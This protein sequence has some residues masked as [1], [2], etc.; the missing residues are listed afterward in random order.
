MVICCA[1]AQ[2]T[3]PAALASVAWADE[4][5]VVDS[6]STD[7][8]AEIARAAADRYV[9]E[10]WRGYTEQKKYGASLARHD[11]V[12][13]LDGDEEVS[14]ALAAELR[15]LD[16]AAVDHLDVLTMPRRNHVL[17]RPVR[18]WWPDTQSRLIHRGR[19]RWSDDVL[20]D[21][22]APSAPGRVRALAGHLEHK[23]VAE[24][25]TSLEGRAASE[26]RPRG[27]PAGWTDY[28]SGARL[29]ARLL[30]TARQMHDRGRRVSWLGLWLRPWFA[31]WKFYLLKRGILDGAFGLLVAQKAMVSTQLK[32]AALWAVQQE[33]RDR[34]PGG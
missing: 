19:A 5:V 24:W 18:A 12:L 23:R 29:D 8:T 34:R 32:Y 6:G 13:V 1:D 3:L 7:A 27:D 20:H 30:D 4:V 14:P 11:W 15:A 25:R 10:P 17:G 28:F 31:F 21:A 16:A 2:A 33:R 26:G 9:V 22:R